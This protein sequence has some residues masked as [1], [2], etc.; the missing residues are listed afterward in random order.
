MHYSPVRHWYCYPFDLHVLGTPPAFVLSQDQTLKFNADSV[1]E[2]IRTSKTEVS[3]ADC[4]VVH[5]NHGLF[6]V[7]LRSKAFPDCSVNRP[8]SITTGFAPLFWILAACAAWV[9]EEVLFPHSASSL[10]RFQKASRF[11]LEPNWWR[12]QDLN[13]RPSGYEPDEIP[14]S[15]PRVI[16]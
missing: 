15:P 13:L 11:K 4:V 7:A 8:G 5:F 6:N 10:F 1:N 2:R 9:F 12:G 14:T 3:S 16:W